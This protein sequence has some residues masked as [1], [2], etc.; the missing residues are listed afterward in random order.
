MKTF[1]RVVCRLALLSILALPCNVLWAQESESALHDEM[2]AINHNFRLVGRQYTDSAQKAST[3]SL[4]AD[5]QKHAEKARTLT[6]PKA[7]KLTGDDQT[8]YV[9]TFHKDIDAL[10]TEIKALQQAIASDKTDVAKAEIDRISQLKASSHKELG[11]G[12]GGKHHGPP[13]TSA[14]PPT[15]PAAPPGQ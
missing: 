5:M 9:D 1:L 6:P 11:V 10:L 14:A 13:P 3:L 7:E 12:G 2:E 4:V 8:K 15:P